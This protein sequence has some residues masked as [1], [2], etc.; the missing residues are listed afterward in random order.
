VRANCII[1]VPLELFLEV[2]IREM[3]IS[4]PAYSVPEEHLLIIKTAWLKWQNLV[5][6]ILRKKL[7]TNCMRGGQMMNPIQELSEQ[8]LKRQPS[9]L[10]Q[11]MVEPPSE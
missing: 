3:I 10:F 1:A 6:S 11:E 8:S 4:P 2:W 7:A 9:H 5:F